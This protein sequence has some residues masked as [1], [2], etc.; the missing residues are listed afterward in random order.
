MNKRPYMNTLKGKYSSARNKK[1]PDGSKYLLTFEEYKSLKEGTCHLCGSSSES[2]SIYRWDDGADFT[3]DTVY[4]CCKQCT[5][6]KSDLSLEGYLLQ[7]AR[8]FKHQIVSRLSDKE[9]IA[10]WVNKLIDKWLAKQ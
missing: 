4:A 7:S 8:V 10:T 9:E 5:K 1:R 2:I 3:Q 6:A